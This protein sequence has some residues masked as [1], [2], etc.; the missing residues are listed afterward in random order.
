MHRIKS[1]YLLSLFLLAL[2]NK[3]NKTHN[4]PQIKVIEEYAF[5]ERLAQENT[6]RA[7]ANLLGVNNWKELVL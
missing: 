7:F 2:R 4:Y 3:Q 5:K 1:K 6:V